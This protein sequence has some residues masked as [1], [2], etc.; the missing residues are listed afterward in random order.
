MG[1]S[2]R[3][4]LLALVLSCA[5]SSKSHPT[6]GKFEDCFYDCKPGQGSAVAS[7]P[8]AAPTGAPAPAA[9]GAKT[10]VTAKA[11]ELR[12][13]ADALEKA[14]AA[15]TNGNKSLAEH[16]FST[17]ELIVGEGAVASIADQFREGGAAAVLT[18]LEEA[19]AAVGGP[20]PYQPQDP[21]IV[22]D[23][24][25]S[26]IA[27]FDAANTHPRFFGY[28]GSS[29]APIA[30]LT[31]AVAAALNRNV[32]TS[33]SRPR[34]VAVELTVIRWLSEMLRLPQ[35]GAGL[36][37]ASGTEA[38][39]VCL[40]AARAAHFPQVRQRGTSVL[41]AS[42]VIYGSRELHLCHRKIV[43]LLGFGSDSLRLVAI[44]AQRRLDLAALRSAIED[45]RAAGRPPFA[46]IAT[47]GTALTGAVDPVD[48]LARLCA[49]ERLWLHVDAAYGGFAILAESDLSASAARHLAAL[50]RADSVAADPHKFLYMPLEAGAAFVRDRTHL[51]GA[52]SAH[53]DYLAGGE[54]DFFEQ[55]L[56]TSR[57]FRALKIWVT[58]RSAGVRA[59]SAAIGRNLRQ[60]RRLYA[61]AASA[62][63]LET[64]APAPELSVACLRYAPN[65]A[66]NVD[67]LN[68]ALVRDL[69]R[70]GDAF[71]SDATVDG[72][73]VIR[74]CIVNLRT[75][76]EDIDRFVALVRAAGQSARADRST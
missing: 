31:E 44:D 64:A 65:A 37:T 11:A 24:V 67:A 57:A 70:G 35:T 53:A 3:L 12:D 22:L 56:A 55:G 48:D 28:V 5:S 71:V 73:P 23:D 17:A 41:S 62:T 30:V 46:G 25:A 45:D 4:G 13:A 14:Q 6:Q 38:N 10:P 8:A 76:D 18:S 32:V 16:Y 39:L 51:R 33:R 66:T 49:S 72:R 9:G 52:F 40:A 2:Q 29:A 34:A 75:R 26:L 7:T 47:A 43:E 20:L 61:I 69:Q 59:F 74:A 36:L 54:H 60:A 42:P 50:G 1:S 21:Q 15:L 58:L 68:R 63:D 19:S 27:P